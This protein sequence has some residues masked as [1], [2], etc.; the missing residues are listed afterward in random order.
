MSLVDICVVTQSPEVKRGSLFVF[1][2]VFVL[3]FHDEKKIKLT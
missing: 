1:M 2:T 3:L